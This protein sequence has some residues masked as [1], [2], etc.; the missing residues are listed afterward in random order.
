M[1]FISVFKETLAKAFPLNTTFLTTNPFD[2]SGRL[3]AAA[4]SP[5]FNLADNLAAIARPVLL[6]DSTNTVAPVHLLHLQL[7]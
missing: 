7:L 5:A 2:V 3:T 6:C 4:T 1:I